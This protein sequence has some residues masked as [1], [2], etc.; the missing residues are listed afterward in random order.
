MALDAARCLFELG[1]TVVGVL[2]LVNLGVFCAFVPFFHFSGP[3]TAPYLGS[4]L[5]LA[6]WEI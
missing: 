3:V 1:E 2:C 5:F 6:P 4:T